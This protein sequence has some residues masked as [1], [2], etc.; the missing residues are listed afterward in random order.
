MSFSTLDESNQE[1][2][3]ETDN[4]D[5]SEEEGKMSAKELMSSLPFSKERRHLL[6]NMMQI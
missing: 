6:F 3:K 5:E 1:V 2:N 4:V